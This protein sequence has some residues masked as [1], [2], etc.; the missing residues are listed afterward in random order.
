MCWRSKKNKGIMYVPQIGVYL[1]KFIAS[2]YVSLEAQRHS[3]SIQSITIAAI[4]MT[5]LLLRQKW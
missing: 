1:V 3:Y 2:F 4:P 5:R